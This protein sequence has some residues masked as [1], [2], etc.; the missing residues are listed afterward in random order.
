MIPKSILVCGHKVRIEFAGTPAGAWGSFEGDAGTIWLH[1]SLQQ[2]HRDKLIPTL[3]HEI[4]HAVSF[5]SGAHYS[6]LDD[7]DGKEEGFA[8]L[9]ERQVFPAIMAIA[10]GKA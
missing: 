6:L 10:R 1:T 5:Y 3:V 2:E 7:D 8:V 4:A 9:V